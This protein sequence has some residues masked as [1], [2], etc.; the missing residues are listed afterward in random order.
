MKKDNY[1]KTADPKEANHCMTT[2]DFMYSEEFHITLHSFC[3]QIS[4]EHKE[5]RQLI[6][7][8]FM[9]RGP[10]EGY[11]D[12]WKISKILLDIFHNHFV[13]YKDIFASHEQRVFFK[14]FIGDF[15]NYFFAEFKPYFIDVNSFIY[16]VD[17]NILMKEKQRLLNLIT[18]TYRLI[19]I[20]L[21]KYESEMCH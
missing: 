16:E 3:K 5:L 4:S 2:K 21:E 11:I 6:N 8:C 12:V 9:E 1:M 20:N 19:M 7:A 13:D 18:D 14:R 10:H 15:Y 17:A